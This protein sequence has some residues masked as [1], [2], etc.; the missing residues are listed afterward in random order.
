M[1]SYY[2]AP[3]PYLNGEPQHHY[4][5]PPLQNG[6]SCDQR[7]YHLQQPQYANSSPAQGATYPRFPPY[8]RLE[9]RPITAHSGEED[10]ESSPHSHYYPQPQQ[11]QCHPQPAHQTNHPNA[12]VPQQQ[13]NSCRGSPPSENGMVVPPQF[14]PQ[15]ENGMVGG[16]PPQ[17]QQQFPSCKMQPMNPA[18]VDYPQQQHCQGSPVH[19]PQHMYPQ[20]GHVGGSQQAPPPQQQNQVQPNAL[21]SPLYPWMKSQ[22]G[23]TS[24]YIIFLL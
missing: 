15:N 19:S 16:V 13:D 22:F 17:Q 2:N 18:A 12:Y 24:F 14:K 20:G 7:Q 9:I 4:N 3:G 1:T 5:S 21:G 6:D 10:S 8:D 23:K 11:Q